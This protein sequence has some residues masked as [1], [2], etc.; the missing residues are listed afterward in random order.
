MRPF[1]TD[2]IRIFRIVAASAA[3]LIA[4][5]PACSAQSTTRSARPDPKSNAAAPELFEY[6][7][8]ALLLLT[9][10]D[11]V[12]DNQEVT[13]N[14]T[15]NVMTIAQPAGHCDLY[16]NALNANDVAWDVFDPSDAHETREKL[17]RLTLVSISGTKARTCY[18]KAGRVDESVPSNRIRFLFSFQKADQWPNFQSKLTKAL[19]RLI[20]LSGGTGNTERF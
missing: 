17:V 9:P 4:V 6:V 19:K 5:L 3:V 16:M 7:R 14:W 13:M 8:S 2:R 1:V 10:E 12:N 20:V 15:T 18:D 11:G